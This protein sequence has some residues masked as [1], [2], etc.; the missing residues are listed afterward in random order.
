MAILTCIGTHFKVIGYIAEDDLGM[1]C[2]AEEAC[3]VAG[4]EEQMRKYLHRM[5]YNGI[6]RGIIRKI[7]FSSIMDG[8]KKGTEYAFDKEAYDRFLPLAE[9]N[10][11]ENL[12][13]GDKFLEEPANGLD[14]LTVRLVA[15]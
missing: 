2:C 8:M 11:V 14:F 4:S 6:G 9:A 15:F 3:I 5:T 13:S 7:R 12:P 10:K 1:T